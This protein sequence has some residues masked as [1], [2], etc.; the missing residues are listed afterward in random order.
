MS[1]PNRAILASFACFGLSL[2]GP[3]FYSG[4]ETA[5]GLDLLMIGWMG[6]LDGV[7]AWMAN[8]LLLAAWISYFNR[9]HRVTAATSILAALFMLSFL[10]VSSVPAS[11]GGRTSNIHAG[12][13][14][15]LWVASAVLAYLG[16]DSQIQK[17]EMDVSTDREQR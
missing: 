8:P 7:V 17:E 11:G 2:V 5:K 13:G 12:W 6:I 16:V 4:G 3:G 10:F 9:R 1:V 14:Y 15:W